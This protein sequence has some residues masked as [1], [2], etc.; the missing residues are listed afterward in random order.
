MP[1]FPAGTVKTAS[2]VK[3]AGFTLV[4]VMM[5]MMII[6][7]MT[8]MVVLNLPEADDSWE[9]QG[10][11]IA[12]KLKIASQSAMIANHTIGI[13]FSK[14]GYRIV[15]FVGGEWRTIEI[16]DFPAEVPLTLA[17]VRNGAEIDLK[18]AE[19]AKLPV[20]RYDPT[21]LATPFDLTID[22]YGR[23]MRFEGAA[24]GSVKFIL[25]G[26]S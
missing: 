25:D 1:I 21:G 2:R 13:R 24:D 7:L 6:G 16:F 11:V 17:L 23:T 12:S 20:I 9:T 26:E 10:R 15:R 19:K 14:N 18:A 8:G 4:E 22:G 3:Q 5:S